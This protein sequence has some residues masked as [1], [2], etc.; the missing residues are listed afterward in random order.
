MDILSTPYSSPG[1]GSI[2]CTVRPKEDS[3]VTVHELAMRLGLTARQIN[4]LVERGIIPPPVGKTRNARYS[5]LHVMEYY[6]YLDIKHNNATMPQV[7]AHCR[8]TGVSLKD[9]VERRTSAI[10]TFGLGVA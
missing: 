2:P 9:Y 10:R 8:A 6:A 7:V 4:K 3:P 1:R 5:N